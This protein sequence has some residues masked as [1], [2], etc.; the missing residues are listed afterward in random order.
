MPADL[1]F[2]LAKAAFGYGTGLILPGY[3]VGRLLRSRAPWAGAL[4]LSMVVLLAG[5]LVLDAFG[6]PVRF[7]TVLAW[8]TLV[9]LGL[10]AGLWSQARKQPAP[11]VAR[12]AGPVAGVSRFALPWSGLLIGGIAL[13]GMLAVW[14][15]FLAPLSGGD[16]VFR[17]EFLARQILRHESLAFYPPVSAED[18]KSY[19]YPDGFA[20]IVSTSIWWVYAALGRALPEAVVPLVLAQYAATLV[21]VFRIAE[22]LHSRPAGWLAAATLAATPLYF[23]SVLIGQETGLTAL[24]VAGS[25]HA[26]VHMEGRRDLPAATLAGLLAASGAL[27]REYGPALLACGLLV[28][29]WRRARWPVLMVFLA[30]AGLLVS[31]WLVRNSLRAGNPL[32]SHSLG[33]FPVN[34]V[35]SGLAE[36]Y[37]RIFGLG[38]L[39]GEAW[40][41]LARRLMSEAGWVTLVGIPAG[42]WLARRQG[43]LVVGAAVGIGLWLL[44]VGY[45]SGLILYSMRVLSPALV[46]LAIPV[47]IALAHLSTTP[48]HARVVSLLLGLSLLHAAGWSAA[49][50]SDPEETGWRAALAGTFRPAPR[51]VPEHD[52]PK[53]LEETLPAWMRILAENA[54]AHAVLVNAGAPH[55][56]VPV[57]SPEVAFLFDRTLTPWQQ[58]L[59]LRERGITAVLFYPDSANTTY[60]MEASPFYAGDASQWDVRAN[61]RGFYLVCVPPRR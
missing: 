17:W 15:G 22:K 9:L 29:A 55:E 48:A 34:P 18:F 51:S 58:R 19:F 38:S 59:R 13:V 61:V 3:L 56:L 60:L 31:A 40:L 42:I 46:L 33:L 12:E 21:L 39:P 2:L 32:Y 49:F 24:A 8:E 37:Q 23:R 41:W 11:A 30:A 45:T 28:L 6:L 52:L 57:W 20:P 43:F 27:A 53:V 36:V 16:M 50:P 14:R 10:G 25:V 1:P 4:P 47:G 26:L 54:R 44:S 35:V 7:A 5:V